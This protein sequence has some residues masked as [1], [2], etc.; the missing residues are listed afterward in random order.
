MDKNSKV[1][2]RAIKYTKLYMRYSIFNPDAQTYYNLMIGA[3]KKLDRT[4]NLDKPAKKIVWD[5][6]LGIS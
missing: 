2:K 1:Y 3:C 6:V 5:D 4:Y